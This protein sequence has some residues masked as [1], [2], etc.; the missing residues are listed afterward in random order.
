MSELEKKKGGAKKGQV[1]KKRKPY[2]LQICE[3]C[4]TTFRGNIGARWHGDRCKHAPHNQ[5]L[6]DFD[7]LLNL[8][9]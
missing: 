2:A 7:K 6:I 4:G 1:Y 3:W 8:S 5:E 9:A